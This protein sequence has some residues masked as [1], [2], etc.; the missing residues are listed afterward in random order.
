MNSAG[1]T[2]ASVGPDGPYGA[3]KPVEFGG[4]YESECAAGG[5]YGA[6]ERVAVDRGTHV[7]VAPVAYVEG[8]LT[9]I[10]PAN[11][12]YNH[13]KRTPPARASVKAH[14]SPMKLPAVV[15]V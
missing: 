13:A 15:I 1:R 9:P 5:R 11:M 14:A 2:K 4:P 12:L 8:C 3:L 10:F 6:L 7:P